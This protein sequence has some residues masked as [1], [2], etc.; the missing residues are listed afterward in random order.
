MFCQN[1][2]CVARCT[3]RNG[4]LTSGV[5][6]CSV[7]NGMFRQDMRCMP[8]C[9]DV[10]W[11]VVGSSYDGRFRRYL[12]HGQICFLEEITRDRLARVVMN[13]V[14]LRTTYIIGTTANVG[15]RAE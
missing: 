6:V 5:A 4:L 1:M 10:S 15:G 11:M 12:L 3:V 9:S 14:K 8:G 7:F 13:E 2:C